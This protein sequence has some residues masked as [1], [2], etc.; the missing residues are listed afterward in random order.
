VLNMGSKQ[1]VHNDRSDVLRET[2]HEP[3]ILSNFPWLRNTAP[4]QHD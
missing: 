1:N 2:F 4:R 3:F